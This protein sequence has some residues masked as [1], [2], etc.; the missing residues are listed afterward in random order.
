MLAAML[1]VRVG[2]V[3]DVNSHSL[4]PVQLGPLSRSVNEAYDSRAWTGNICLIII[5]IMI[6]IV[7]TIVATDVMDP[8]LVVT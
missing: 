7:I 2:S 4:G 3:C 6:V 5:I 8:S 1:S